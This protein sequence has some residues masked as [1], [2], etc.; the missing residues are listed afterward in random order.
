MS[1]SDIIDIPTSHKIVLVEFDVGRGWSR[2]S[3]YEG[4]RIT[5]INHA[6]GIYLAAFDGTFG[7]SET[8]TQDAA[9]LTV[10]N[11]GGVFYDGSNRLQRVGTVAA[12]QSQPSFYWDGED[13]YLYI[14]LPDWNPP[15]V[16]TLTIGIATQV[17]R[18]HWIDETNSVQY[19]GSLL[20][21][22]SVSKNIDRLFFGRV[23]FDGG[24][25]TIQ[26]R[27]GTY[28]QLNTWDVYGQETRLYFGSAEDTDIADHYQ[29]WTGYIEDF[30]ISEDEAQ[31]NIADKRKALQDPIPPNLFDKTTYPDL[32]DGDENEPIPLAYGKI[33]RAVPT[34]VNW[35]IYDTTLDQDLTFKLCDMTNHDAI[36]A[37]DTV[38]Y[39]DIALPTADVDGEIAWTGSDLTNATITINKDADVRLD[40]RKIS[41]TFQGYE[42][43]SGALI[44][45]GLDVIKDV[46]NIY[47]GVPYTVANYDITEW[48][49]AT[50]LTP[51]VGIYIDKETDIIKVIEKVASSMPGQ[52]YVKDNGLFTFKQYA[53][54]TTPVQNIYQVDLLN[55][56]LTADYNS[57][58][59]LSSAKV[60]YYNGLHYIDDSNEGSVNERFKQKRQKIFE[61]QL[62]SAADAESFADTITAFSYDLFP[63]FELE[64]DM[65]TVELEVEDIVN[66]ELNR[67]R[68]EWFGWAEC[69]VEGKQID[70]NNF[71]VTLTVR[72]LKYGL[73]D[74]TVDGGDAES[75]G[76]FIYDG[77]TASTTFEN[78]LSGGNATTKYLRETA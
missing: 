72:V 53:P 59:F 33:R 25:L 32:D 13:E 49:A 63:V 68:Q 34:C 1:Y 65:R 36:A 69:R 19:D 73:L 26:N 74:E 29:V 22:P 42:D 41:V 61:T 56:S 75:T 20:S 60:E 44:A 31:V 39:D 5:W 43:S 76:D 48:D 9:T 12:L 46:M 3:T 40:R 21:V 15:D 45:N 18:E 16:H 28:D 64:T 6:P 10:T 24:S 54:S 7:I 55:D 66:V 71:T 58:E 51:E 78:T 2:Y 14:R 23:S 47:G 37:I 70:L 52:F 17:A 27:D 11:I 30:A 4:A 62:T 8:W 77:G 67:L 35:G 38:Y 50:T 57:Q